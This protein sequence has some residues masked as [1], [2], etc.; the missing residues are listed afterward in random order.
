MFT[1]I[2]NLFKTK[3]IVEPIIDSRPALI[4]KYKNVVICKY[5]AQYMAMLE[6]VDQYSIGHVDIQTDGYLVH[7]G[8]EYADDALIFRIMYSL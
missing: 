3:D 5:T 7:F 2:Y 1:R 4:L 8:F 6:W